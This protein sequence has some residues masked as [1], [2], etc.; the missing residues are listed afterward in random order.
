MI[1]GSNYRGAMGLLNLLQ[2][3]L[4]HYGYLTLFVAL[5]VNNLG[6]PFP[7]TSVLLATGLLVGKGILSFWVTVVIATSAC[8]LGSNCGYLL[9]LRFGLP[10]LKKI[11]WLRLTHHR[12]KHLELFFKRYGPH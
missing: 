1:G 2:A 8:F 6:I 4:A 3:L 12:I 7:G 5:F 11:H 10:L 9:G